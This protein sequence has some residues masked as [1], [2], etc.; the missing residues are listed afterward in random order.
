MLMTLLDSAVD[1]AL[2]V[3]VF[4]LNDLLGLNA[5]DKGFLHRIARGEPN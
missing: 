2:R 1:L 3:L 4:D 5:L